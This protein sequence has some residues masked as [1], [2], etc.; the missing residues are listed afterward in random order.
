[1]AAER[2]EKA[3]PLLF[4]HSTTVVGSVKPESMRPTAAGL[5]VA[6]EVDR[7]T[8]EGRQVWRSIKSGVCGFSIGF[9]SE[10]RARPGG[11]RVLTEVDLIEVS[12]TSTP[13]HP[14]T[15]AISWKSAFD[16]D[17]PSDA[18]QKAR[19]A[20][21]MFTDEQ[22]QDLRRWLREFN[23]AISGTKATAPATKS[24]GPVRLARFPV[25]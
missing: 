6:G 13:M 12:A 5:V 7:S 8:D 23:E 2:G 10:S 15:R 20:M 11:G 17:V 24:K 14:A 18:D 22:E 19:F 16:V 4:E 3:L 21:L 1:V 9:M 25:E